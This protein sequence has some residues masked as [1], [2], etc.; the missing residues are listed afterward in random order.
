LLFQIRSSLEEAKV[1][2]D[3]YHLKSAI[4]LQRFSRYSLHTINRDSRITKP[5]NN[6][7]EGMLVEMEGK[8][9][10]PSMVVVMG[11][12]G[13]GKSYF[14]NQLAGKEVVQEGSNLDSCKQLHLYDCAPSKSAKAHKSVSLYRRLLVTAKCS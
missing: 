13:A 8:C 3:S 9:D 1:R 4:V 10:A 12:T 11:V 14:I 5:D 6:R 2:L 7:A